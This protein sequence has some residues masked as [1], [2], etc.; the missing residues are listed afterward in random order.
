MIELKK[1]FFS[2]LFG[3]IKSYKKKQDIGLATN[4]TVYFE[5]GGNNNGIYMCS[6]DLCPCSG[7]KQLKPG[8]SAYLYISEGVVERR[9]TTITLKEMEERITA[10]SQANHIVVGPGTWNPILVCK[11]AAKRMGLDLKVASDDASN[12]LKTGMCPLR[13]T[14][15]K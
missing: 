5:G 13:P 10:S 11:Q 1:G 9:S 14:P 6:D 12:W 2:S 15:I 4:R 7:T 8:K 3:K